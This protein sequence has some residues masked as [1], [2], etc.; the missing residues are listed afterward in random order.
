MGSYL[1]MAVLVIGFATMIFVINKKLSGSK[2]DE[3]IVSWLKTM[4]NS[5]DTRLDSATQ[6]MGQIRQDA[7]RF[8]ELSLSM[9]NLQDYLKSPKLRG[10]IGEE[11]LKDLISQMFPKNSFFLQYAFKSGDK[12]DAAIKTEAG[13]LPIDSKFPAENFQ[14]MMA[15]ENE[16][17]KENARKDFTRDVKKH[18]TDIS[19]KY[20]LPEEGTMDFALMYIPSE[21]VYYELVNDMEITEFARKNRVYPVSPNTLYANLQ[22]ILLSF[23]GKDIELKS[24]Q[25]FAVL[26]GIQKDYGKLG[27]RLSLLNKHLTNAY[28]QMSSVGTEYTLM[29][30]KLSSTQN[31]EGGEEIKR[32]SSKD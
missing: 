6:L 15:S 1:I 24:H 20:I 28:N 29:G 19:Q 2:Q 4:Q 25:L 26:R 11:V 10:N 17:E 31:L 7:G 8:A 9:K 30:Q 3:T 14:K 12:V 23:Q 32:I 18:I 27:E 13:I 21:P 16:A 22:V 5:L